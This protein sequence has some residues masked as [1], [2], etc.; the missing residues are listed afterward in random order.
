MSKPLLIVGVQ[1]GFIN[2]FT[3]YIPQRVACLIKRGEY[4]PIL[5]SRFINL[6][7]GPYQRKLA[8]FIS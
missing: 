6:P 3:H 4:E 2:S 5:F 7:E 8:I 1:C